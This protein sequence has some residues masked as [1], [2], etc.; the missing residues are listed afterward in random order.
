MPDGT[1]LYDFFTGATEND[2]V[3]MYR[4]ATGL[5][6]YSSMSLIWSGAWIPDRQ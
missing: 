1:Y 4:D 3:W 6:D 2:V 5:S